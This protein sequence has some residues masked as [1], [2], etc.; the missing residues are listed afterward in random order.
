M[1]CKCLPH[2]TFDSLVDL[3]E[4]RIVM[5]QLLFGLQV[6]AI[7]LWNF[8]GRG[9]TKDPKPSI[10]GS[11]SVGFDHFEPL[12]S[13]TCQNGCHAEGSFRDAKRAASTCQKDVSCLKEQNLPESP[14]P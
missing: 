3:E 6:A 4:I 14:S 13:S 7:N 2:V 8:V 9:P 10:L 1:P 5:R 11:D 12:I